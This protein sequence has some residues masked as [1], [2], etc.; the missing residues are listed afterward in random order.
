MTGGAIKF[1]DKRSMGKQA[2][3]GSF[4]ALVALWAP[5]GLRPHEI[6]DGLVVFR[7]NA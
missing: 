2:G 3:S 1:V 6:Q 5:E 4:D 7:R